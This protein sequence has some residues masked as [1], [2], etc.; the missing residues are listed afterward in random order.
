MKTSCLVFGLLVLLMFAGDKNAF[1]NEEWGPYRGVNVNPFITEED[2]S[3][4]ARLGGNLMRVS[5]GKLPMISKKPPYELNEEAFLRLDNI[6]RWAKKYN[7]HVVIDP[8]TAPGFRRL[9]TTEPTDEFWKDY[10]WHDYLVNLW[11]SV[12]KRYSKEGEV[13]AGYDLLNEPSVPRGFMTNSPGDWNALVR[14]LV[15]EIRLHDTLHWIIVE[16]AV[17]FFGEKGKVN[18]LQGIEFLEILDDA[19][20]VYSPHMYEPHAFTHQ[21]VGMR[22]IGLSY[23]SVI[24]GNRWN[25]EKIIEALKPVRLFQQA[26]KVNIF[27]GEFGLSPFVQ[28]GGGQYL[29]DVIEIFTEYKWSWAVH[30]FRSGGMWSIETKRINSQLQ[31]W[32]PIDTVQLYFNSGN[33]NR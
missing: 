15:S 16:P 21:G 26:H 4:L 8:H 23:P 25:R 19:R 1:A 12:A 2:V 32:A 3:D 7:I 22:N 24:D 30:N 33:R 31:S 10:R 27:I 13:I 6:I 9:F 20:I 28:D 29:S 17:G 5:F 11:S 14:R 18:R